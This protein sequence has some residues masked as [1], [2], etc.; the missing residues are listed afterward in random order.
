[1]QAGSAGRGEIGRGAVVNVSALVQL[2]PARSGVLASAVPHTYTRAVAPTT[3]GAGEPLATSPPLSFDPVPAVM[4]VIAID[5]GGTKLATAIFDAGGTLLH[6]DSVPLDGRTGSEVA[7]L[8]AQRCEGATGG[9]GVTVPGIYPAVR[10]TV[11]A[12]NIPG[13]D[14]YPLRDELRSV[15]G[16]DTPV[17]IDSDRA[18]Y[19]L[20]EVW[21]GAARGAR[22]AI[23]LAV[24]TGIGAGIMVD[25]RVLRGHGD[26]GG[27]IGWLALDRP[28]REEYRSCGCFEYHASGPGL[29]KVARERLARDRNYNGEL[30]K[31][32]P[33][34]L[35]AE[36][37]FAA[38]DKGDAIATEVLDDAVTFW[39]MAAANL[40]SL[41][42]PEVIVFG[43]GVFGPAARFM[44][45]IQEEAI[46][47]AQ[48]IAVTETRFVASKLG[49]DAG[50]YG[51]ARLALL[52]RA[53]MPAVRKEAKHNDARSAPPK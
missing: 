31:V 4:P 18:G 33:L 19:I 17:V 38:Y 47:W 48:P 45:R 13:W 39:A 23:F 29:A 42:N 3:I 44:D 36:R 21:R 49:G 40:V 5:L 35:T 9:A 20:G 11:W 34:A 51:A 22:H 32:D 24:G 28:Y 15:V 6:R 10:G 14:D 30:R 52:A 37:I 1:M 43:G 7:A 41:F 2:S 46:R 27:A 12:P 8:V 50:L 26:I 16:P 25:G 53:E